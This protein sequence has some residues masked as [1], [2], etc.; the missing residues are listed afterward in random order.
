MARLLLHKVRRNCVWC[1]GVDYS[2]HQLHPPTPTPKDSSP[3][4][5]SSHGYQIGQP[6]LSPK[7]LI[8]TISLVIS[9]FT[10]IRYRKSLHRSV[11][12]SLSK[13]VPGLSQKWSH[14]LGFRFRSLLLA[15]RLSAPYSRRWPSWPSKRIHSTP[16]LAPNPDPE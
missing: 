16:H 5:L 14:S 10:S 13:R 12:P 15:R 3:T 11:S 7:H 9:P 1:Y 8:C 4:Y 6:S 2:V